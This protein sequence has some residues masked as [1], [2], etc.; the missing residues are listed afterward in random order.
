MIIHVEMNEYCGGRICLNNEIGQWEQCLR[1]SC[2][3]IEHEEST[4]GIHS[5][6]A[7]S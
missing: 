4:T 5:D 2:I 1:E 3:V 7:R 6:T